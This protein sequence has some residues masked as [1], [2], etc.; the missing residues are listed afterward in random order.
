[1]PF[2]EPN[3]KKLWEPGDLVYGYENYRPEFMKYQLREN[4]PHGRDLMK[5]FVWYIDHLK[6]DGAKP[7][8]IESTAEIEYQEQLLESA[9]KIHENLR[10]EWADLEPKRAQN[11]EKMKELRSSLDLMK[12][13]LAEVLVSKEKRST[14]LKGSDT[15][16]F[17][18]EMEAGLLKRLEAKAT[19]LTNDIR[20]QETKVEEQR[21]VHRQF[22]KDK[23]RVETSRENMVGA[24]RE[25]HERALT[26]S[27]GTH[28]MGDKKYAAVL[29]PIPEVRLPVEL[30]SIFRRKSKAGLQWA[31]KAPEV[32]QVHF[33]LKG[34][35][36][37]RVVL[38]DTP[39]NPNDPRRNPEVYKDW[40]TS[41]SEKYRV[42]T[43]SELRWLFRNRA[44]PE[45]A[46]K[47][48]FWD[49]DFHPCRPPWAWGAVWTM[50]WEKTYV[51][52]KKA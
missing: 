8:D 31:V 15:P 18:K 47:V 12:A 42:I 49:K 34:I 9:M 24:H 3:F 16:P 28:L 45:V 19:E 11:K 50:F 20:D 38:K 7:E 1:M 32:G 33:V 43:H 48:Q 17:L 5:A 25:L 6:M 27:F 39:A 29:K 44:V 4:Y 30:N 41:D 2:D 35:D 46:K 51:P 21:S 40:K 13:E 52:H 22:T 37:L 36:M 10:A 26:R 23:D 14:S